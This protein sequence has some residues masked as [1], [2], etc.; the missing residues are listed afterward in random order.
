[1]TFWTSARLKQA[2]WNWKASRLI[3]ANVWKGRV[4]QK[5]FLGDA[6][7]FRVSV[8]SRALMSRQHP[9]VRTKV[10]AEIFVRVDPR[11]CVV[12]TP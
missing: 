1:M 5:V 2:R 4:E 10:G 11:K 9:D 8:G 7:D 12:L 3:C 6:V